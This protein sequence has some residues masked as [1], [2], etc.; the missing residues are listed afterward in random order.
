MFELIHENIV[1]LCSCYA[2][3]FVLKLWLPSILTFYDWYKII[4]ESDIV[5]DYYRTDIKMLWW[6]FILYNIIMIIF[7]FEIV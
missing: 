2:N 7:I 3:F 1:L 6:W 4:I 5:N